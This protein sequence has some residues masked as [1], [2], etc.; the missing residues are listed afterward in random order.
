MKI[1]FTYIQKGLVVRDL[2]YSF[3]DVS[4][5][6]QPSVIVIVITMLSVITQ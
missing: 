4:K 3:A 2:L 6:S 5:H 1:I